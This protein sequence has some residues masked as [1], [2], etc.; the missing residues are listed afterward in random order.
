MLYSQKT[1]E[2]F[3]KVMLDETGMVIRINLEEAIFGINQNPNIQYNPYLPIINTILVIIKRS[4]ILQRENKNIISEDQIT[5]IIDRQITKEHYNAQK[6]NR[7][8]QFILRW[9]DIARQKRGL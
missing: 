8:T 1:I 7:K 3:E 9:P 4:L 2:N 6:T 5:K